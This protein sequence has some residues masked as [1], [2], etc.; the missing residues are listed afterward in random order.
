MLGDSWKSGGGALEGTDTALNSRIERPEDIFF[1]EGDWRCGERDVSD[2]G[3]HKD[4]AYFNG[5]ELGEI[6]NGGGLGSLDGYFNG[7]E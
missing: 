3:G 2:G 6:M 7:G 5:G 1:F 4:T